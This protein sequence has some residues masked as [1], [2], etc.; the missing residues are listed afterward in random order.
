VEEELAWAA[1][2]FEAK[3]S[4]SRPGRAPLLQVKTSEEGSVR[5]FGEAVRLGKVYG[6]YGP[7]KG[8][9]GGSPYWVWVARG[10]KAT[11]VADLLR[12][13]LSQGLLAKLDSQERV[14]KPRRLQNPMKGEA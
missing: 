6:S 10:W 1:G 9:L 2:F 4:V 12:P 11:A 13:F 8:Q 5:R 3:G 14:E 7:Y